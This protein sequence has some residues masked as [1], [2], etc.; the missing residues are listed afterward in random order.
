MAGCVCVSINITALHSHTCS[1]YVHTAAILVQVVPVCGNL[2]T[3]G[4]EHS[5]ES[6]EL[7]GIRIRSETCRARIVI[8][9]CGIEGVGQAVSGHAR[10]TI[11]GDYSNALSA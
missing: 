3:E 6:P 11:G 7:C 1:D 2:L 8:C 4:D 9:L 10:N 5:S